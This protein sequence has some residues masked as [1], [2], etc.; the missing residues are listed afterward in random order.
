[1]QDHTYKEGEKWDANILYTLDGKSRRIVSV[2]RE[3]DC[4]C[5]GSYHRTCGDI[6]GQEVKPVTED[7]INWVK[8]GVKP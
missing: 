3:K 2:W 5:G 6:Y 4:G 1:M 8:Y 7:Q